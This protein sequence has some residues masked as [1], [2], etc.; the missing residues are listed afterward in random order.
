MEQTP[1]TSFIPKQAPGAP[2][3][4]QRRT[5]NVLSFVAMVIFLAVLA[6]S[7]GVFFYHEYSATRLEERKAELA[8][9]KSQFSEEDISHIKDLERRLNAARTLLDGHISLS[10]IFDA[11]EASTQSNAQLASFTY[12]RQPSGGAQVSL[13]GDATSFNTVA[14]QEQRF[15]NEK[16]FT[17]GS[18]IFSD[19][20]VS[21]NDTG[22][23]T[24]SFS[25]AADIDTKNVAFVA[26]AT[27][28]VS[29][30]VSGSEG[31]EQVEGAATTTEVVSG[32][33]TLPLEE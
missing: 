25:V 21:N 18:V 12:S 7:V 30:V 32:R 24:V 15:L 2:A 5:F 33:E 28:I 31:Q 19:L 22:R 1:R 16:A 11:L 6:L 9:L 13:T 8:Q 14:L 3:R 17:R 27:D 4:R 20:S 23:K 10:R 29:E 26:P